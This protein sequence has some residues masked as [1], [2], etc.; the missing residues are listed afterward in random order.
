M[1]KHPIDPNCPARHSD[2][3][4]WWENTWFHL[5]AIARRTWKTVVLR[6]TVC[7]WR[8]HNYDDTEWGHMIG[9]KTHDQWCARCDKFRGIPCAEHPKYDVPK[10]F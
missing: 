5:L 8:G 4:Y 6:R 7:S 1:P 9:S 3:Y 2:D 10:F